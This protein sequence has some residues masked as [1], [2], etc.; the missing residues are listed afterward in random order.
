MDQV[1][2]EHVGFMDGGEIM[3]RPLL[4]DLLS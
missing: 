4:T 1:L 3:A 2:L